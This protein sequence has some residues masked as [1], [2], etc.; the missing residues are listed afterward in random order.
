[1]IIE[2]LLQYNTADWFFH[3]FLN[4]NGFNLKQFNLN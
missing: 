1:M 4:I 2:F 3:C